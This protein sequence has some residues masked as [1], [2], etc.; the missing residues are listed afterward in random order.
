MYKKLLKHLTK[1]LFSII[2]LILTLLSKLFFALLPTIIIL[3]LI[4][5]GRIV[6]DSPSAL[7]RR[8]QQE[9]IHDLF[10][11]T[12]WQH[13]KP[14]GTLF[15]EQEQ[16]QEALQC[17]NEKVWPTSPIRSTEVFDTIAPRCYIVSVDSPDVA[18]TR[19]F[20]FLP[21]V[22]PFTGQIGAVVGVYQPETRT[23]FVVE[24][25]DA[26]QVYRHELQ[27]YF[28]H[29]HDPITQGGGH[30]QNIWKQ[31]EAPY[32]TPSEKTKLVGVL[33]NDDIPS[34]LEKKENQ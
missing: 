4:A 12:K 29:V 2:L 18:G 32:Y 16:F 9:M 24:N 30:Y 33:L 20:N 3:Q 8:A 27:H 26:K 25:V 34:A 19:E 21:I 10:P 22:N 17:V 13:L 1:K 23:V 5:S 11:N 31:C 28:L 6:L 15:D 14:C 7:P